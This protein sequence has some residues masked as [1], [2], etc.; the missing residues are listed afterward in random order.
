L[1]GRR[2]DVLAA[3]ARIEAA[4]SAREAARAAFYPDI[5]L[6]AFVGVQAIGL[7][8]LVESG[9]RTYGVGPALHL[10][11]FDAQR[12]RA[13]Y[14]GATAQLDAAIATYNATVLGAI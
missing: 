1:L 3:R 8:E 12:L 14:K 13:A 10:P 5:N 9:S 2:P 4:A 6:K 11:I 7:D